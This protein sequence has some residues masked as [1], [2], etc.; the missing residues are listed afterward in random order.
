MNLSFLKNMRFFNIEDGLR[1]LR[2]GGSI[3]MS[4]GISEIVALTHGKEHRGMSFRV[5]GFMF[6]GIVVVS[7]NG[8][9]YYEAR[10]FKDDELVHTI[11]D[12]YVDDFI[13]IIDDYVEYDPAFYADSAKGVV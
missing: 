1:L 3:P 7:V 12:I 2:R 11:G 9:D 13:E 10:F 4:W 5:N 6:Q 8:A